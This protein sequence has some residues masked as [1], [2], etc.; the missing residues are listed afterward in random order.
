MPLTK[1][2]LCC[3]T[4]S[5]SANKSPSS[6]IILSSSSARAAFSPKPSISKILREPR[7]SSRPRSCAGQLRVLRHRKSLSSSFSG[8][9][10]LPHSGHLV[11]IW[12]SRSEPSRSSTTGPKISGITSPALRRNT[13][14]PSNKPLRTTSYPLCKVA[15]ET[16]E[17]ATST[18]ST[19][20]RGV[21]RP[22][23]PT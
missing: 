14:S 15:K 5:V 7:C 9:N 12:N 21:M 6:E 17:P 11:G 1:K 8:A 18:G 16:V 20:A 3:R 19:A 23:R 22:V 2:S 10:K 13:M 4:S